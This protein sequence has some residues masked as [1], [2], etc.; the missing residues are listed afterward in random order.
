MTDSVTPRRSFITRLAA[1]AAVIG[2]TPAVAAIGLFG[3]GGT[4]RRARGR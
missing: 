1:G 3:G 2:A 4:A